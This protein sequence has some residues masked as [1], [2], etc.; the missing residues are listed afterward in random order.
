MT[1]IAFVQMTS[2]ANLE[3][4]LAQMEAKVKEA[5]Q[6]GAYMVIFPEM[7]YFIGSAAQALKIVDSFEP[8]LERFSKMASN[9]EIAVLPGTLREPVP[10]SPGRYFNTLPVFS[11]QGDPVAYY[12]KLHLFRATLPDHEYFEGKYC[13]AGADVVTVEIAGL[14]VGLAICYDL[15]FPELFRALRTKRV[16]LVVLPSAFTV[17]TGKAHWETLVR[18]RAIENQF[19]MVAPGQTGIT[20]DGKPTHGHSMAVGPWGEILAEKK[21]ETGLVVCEIEPRQIRECQAK[22]DAWASRRE[23]LLPIP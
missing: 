8:V 15:R 6:A 7:A 19:F 1:R 4:N 22:V 11:V 23:E 21:T 9:Y 5:A 16:E 18:A 3:D 17:P 14:E 12:R 2:S 10:G 13:E 20:G